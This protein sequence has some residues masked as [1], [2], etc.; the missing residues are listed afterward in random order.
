MQELGYNYRITDIQCALGISQL[1][2]KDKF[3][4]RRK[5]IAKIYDQFFSEYIIFSIPTIR[6]NSSHAYHLYPL[7]IDFNEIKIS[8]KKLFNIMKSKNINLQ[9]HYVPVHLHPYYRKMY[10]FKVGDFPIAEKFYK[11]E[12][13]LPIYFSLK[14]RQV[15][16]IINLIKKFC[17]N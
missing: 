5:E 15:Y 12:V 3:V 17:N 8:K 6:E 16:N 7:Q 11:N 1:K 13:S 2:K 9:V 4:K 14:D 10:N